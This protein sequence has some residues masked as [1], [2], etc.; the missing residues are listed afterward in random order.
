[1][2][3]LGL[4]VF[5]LWSLPHHRLLCFDV[6]IT[7][8]NKLLP[9]WEYVHNAQIFD[10]SF[11]TF[12]KMPD[13]II[14]GVFNEPEAT[15]TSA[16]H[17]SNLISLPESY[18]TSSAIEFALKD[19]LLSYQIWFD[20]QPGSTFRLLWKWTR[21]PLHHR[22]LHPA[23][24]PWHNVIGSL[25]AS[26]CPCR[27]GRPS[28]NYPA[29]FCSDPQTINNSSSPAGAPSSFIRSWFWW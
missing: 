15:E 17:K 11:A 25:E 28:C 2:C 27:P 3:V 13:S 10:S 29:E 14:S 24:V 6:G 12:E 4:H 18:G 19:K 16:D 1:M 22:V 21:L 9:E 5:R 26:V 23:D 20:K 8:R 7:K